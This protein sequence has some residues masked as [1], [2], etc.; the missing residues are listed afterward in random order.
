[1]ND[2]V[3]NPE[4][5]TIFLCLAALLCQY[6]CGFANGGAKVSNAGLMWCSRSFLLT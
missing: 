4:E 1:M 3:T 5:D 2:Q 6:F